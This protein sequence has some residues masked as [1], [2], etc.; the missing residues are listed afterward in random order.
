MSVYF[1]QLFFMRLLQL[2]YTRFSS[3][4]KIAPLTSIHFMIK[5]VDHKQDILIV[6]Y[7]LAVVRTRSY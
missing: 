1:D 7:F 5:Y 4:Q 6:H 2:S 3:K